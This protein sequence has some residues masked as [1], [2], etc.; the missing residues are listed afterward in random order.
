MGKEKKKFSQN[1][2]IHSVPIWKEA[3]TKASTPNG[4]DAGP[5]P[6]LIILKTL[7]SGRLLNKNGLNK[8]RITLKRY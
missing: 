5:K 1:S 6:S 8:V 3:P 2:H 4:I 7:D